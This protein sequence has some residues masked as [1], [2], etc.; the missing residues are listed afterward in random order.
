[1]TAEKKLIMVV[2]DNLTNLNACIYALMDNYNVVPAT[3]AEKMFKLLGKVKPD[4]I[5]LDVEM[6]EVDGYEALKRLKAD[7]K[8]AEIPVIF[9][10]A[11]LDP[12]E[13]AEGLELGALDYVVKPFSRHLL[14][15]RLE[16]YLELLERRAERRQ[17]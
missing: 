12:E 7:P 10:T 13:A 4:L 9:V 5:L 1:M 11:L 6:P 3:S 17:G 8:T 2:D 16:N 15:K 14:L